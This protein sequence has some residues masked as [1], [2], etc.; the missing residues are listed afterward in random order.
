MLLQIFFTPLYSISVENAIFCYLKI[1][2]LCRWQM[3]EIIKFG[4]NHELIW[5]FIRGNLEFSTT[6]TKTLSTFI[7]LPYLRFV[8][9]FHIRS[10]M[11][12]RLAKLNLLWSRKNRPRHEVIVKKSCHELPLLLRCTTCTFG[13]HIWEF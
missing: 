10:K 1:T 5:R 11:R 9:E 3:T 13:K 7:S 2:E 8:R 4:Q 12:P 6:L